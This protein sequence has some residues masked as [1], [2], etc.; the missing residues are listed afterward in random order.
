ME[1]IVFGSGRDGRIEKEEEGGRV[2][3][4]KWVLDFTRNEFLLV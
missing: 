2:S 4:K 1:V 3:G